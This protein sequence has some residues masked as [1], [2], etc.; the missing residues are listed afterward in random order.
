MLYIPS[1][2]PLHFWYQVPLPGVPLDDQFILTSEM[3]RGRPPEV[4][5]KSDLQNQQMWLTSL[6]RF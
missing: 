2:H 3:K 6:K 1:K 4:T 5:L